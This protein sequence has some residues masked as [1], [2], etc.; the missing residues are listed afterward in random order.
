MG[1]LRKESRKVVFNVGFT[2]FLIF[3][4]SISMFLHGVKNITHCKRA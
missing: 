2:N 4:Q 1:G 3:S